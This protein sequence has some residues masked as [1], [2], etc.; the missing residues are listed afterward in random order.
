L[1]TLG[2]L[3]C[4][5]RRNANRLAR[6]VGVARGKRLADRILERIEAERLIAAPVLS[7]P[8]TPYGRE[9]DR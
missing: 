1:L 9:R 4:A 6:F 5:R 2:H 8:A 3:K 7:L